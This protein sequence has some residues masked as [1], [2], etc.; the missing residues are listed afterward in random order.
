MEQKNIHFEHLGWSLNDE[1]REGRRR[2]EEGR[3]R[4]AEG[5][6]GVGNEKGKT[7]MQGLDCSAGQYNSQEDPRLLSVGLNCHL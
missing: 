1:R 2:G 5:Q 6:K 3:R 7:K 4:R